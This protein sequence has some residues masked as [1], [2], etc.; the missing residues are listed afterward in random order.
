MTSNG[1]SLRNGGPIGSAPTSGS[2]EMSQSNPSTANTTAREAPCNQ[3]GT[4]TKTK[5]CAT[6]KSPGELGARGMG[7]AC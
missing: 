5:D 3:S 4:N 2:G 1:Q 7:G 6:F